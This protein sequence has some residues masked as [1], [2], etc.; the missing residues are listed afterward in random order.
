MSEIKPFRYLAL[1]QPPRQPRST[2]FEP[3][4]WRRKPVKVGRAEIVAPL[5]AEEEKP[6]N[7]DILA[8]Y[9]VSMASERH[10][11]AG[12]VIIVAK[13]FVKVPCTR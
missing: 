10:V 11:K 1:G 7:E 5:G 6:L 9:D 4:N 2:I 8:L 13:P 3:K 12:D